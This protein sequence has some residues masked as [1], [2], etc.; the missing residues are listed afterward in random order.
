MKGMC[1]VWGD[2]A[3]RK[4][5]FIRAGKGSGRARLG[6]GEPAGRSTCGRERGWFPCQSCFPRIKERLVKILK[7][8]T[9]FGRGVWHPGKRN[10]CPAVG[11][12]QPG[13][14]CP[15]PADL[16]VVKRRFG[17]FPSDHSAQI[18]LEVIF[19]KPTLH[20]GGLLCLFGLKSP[21]FGSRAGETTH[22]YKIPKREETSALSTKAHKGGRALFAE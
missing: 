18:H 11:G 14:L 3:E 8:S 19:T 9:R 12:T 15:S 6:K 7:S 17:I 21:G 20:S 1:W 5:S 2:G 22:F 16:V 4:K 13:W 10:K